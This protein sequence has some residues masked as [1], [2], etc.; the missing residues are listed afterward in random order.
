MIMKNNSSKAEQREDFFFRII[1]FF[2]VIITI[3]T[4]AS[5][6]SASAQDTTANQANEKK[7]IYYQPILFHGS[8]YLSGDSQSVISKKVIRPMTQFSI[9]DVLNSTYFLTP[10]S[11]G[12]FA[13]NNS[14]SMYGSGRHDVGLRYNTRS[15]SNPLHGGV[16]LAQ[17]PVETAENIEVMMGTPAIVLG[18]NSSGIYINLQEG[19]HN[20]ATPFTRLRYAQSS[21]NFIAS[22]GEFSQ[23]PAPNWNID[24]GFRRHVGE[25]RFANSWVDLW[26]V[27][28]K[29]RWTQSRSQ[30]TLSHIF[31]NYGNGLNGGLS[32]STTTYSD[33][34][35]ARVRFN[36]MFERTI[37]HDLTLSYSSINSDST[38]LHSASAYFSYG[39]W[40]LE[41]NIQYNITQFDSSRIIAPIMRTL[42]VMY[43]GS[44]KFSRQISVKFGGETEQHVIDASIY[45]RNF[46]GFSTALFSLSDFQLSPLL[47]IQ[48]GVRLRY[49]HNELTLNF[50]AKTE[51]S[52]FENVVSGIDISLSSRRPSLTEGLLSSE[53]HILG[54]G[55]IQWKGSD[56]R[57]KCEVFSRTVNDL[58]LHEALIR[59]NG[60]VGTTAR[61]AG[62][63]NIV[64]SS[65]NGYYAL[66]S[67]IRVLGAFLWQHSSTNGVFDDRLPSFQGMVGAE[68]T[69]VFGRS[70]VKGGV[71]LRIISSSYGELFIPQTHGSILLP[72][73]ESGMTSN[74]GQAFIGAQ[75]G[76]AYVQFTLYNIL[77]A[78]YWSTPLYTELD[79][80]LRISVNWSFFD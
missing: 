35:N 42:G 22:E 30:W 29:I 28:A 55:Y 46:S 16:N 13:Q 10:L 3:S 2:C 19:I 34:I 68:Y 9:F 7:I 71:S 39:T 76:N 36:D 54:I 72:N 33:P 11:L 32:D 61:N 67:S 4:F 73:K 8:F 79:R 58:I 51:Y 50:G 37:N 74:G 26:N 31:T 49:F 14:V 17:F 44:V 65:I 20:S 5:A 6:A 18:D 69:R 21:Y 75:L 62:V 24:A 64:G 59:N 1:H 77:N 38:V 27:Y 45:N 70:T 53:K 41:K 78:E 43:M 15:I 56:H 25:G 60:I 80:H 12:G 40:T 52:V 47:R 48:P 23:N 63:R 66:N 57:I